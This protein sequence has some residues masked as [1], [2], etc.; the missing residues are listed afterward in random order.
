[1]QNYWEPSTPRSYPLP[2][3]NVRTTHHCLPC[4]SYLYKTQWLSIADSA[5][6]LPQPLDEKY[7][8]LFL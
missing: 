4:C 8:A 1:M 5:S 7:G 2:L 6:R 3:E